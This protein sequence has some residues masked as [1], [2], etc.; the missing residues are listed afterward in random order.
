MKKLSD[1]K[2]AGRLALALAVPVVGLL[3][4]A[5]QGVLAEAD[6]RSI[7]DRLE[8]GTSLI[9]HLSA[10][11]HEVQR[12]RGRSNAVAQTA[13]KQGVA[14]YGAQ[15][16]V[17]DKAIADFQTALKAVDTSDFWPAV[18]TQLTE[19]EAALNKLSAIRAETRSGSA[20][21]TAVQQGYTAVIQEL[22]D[23]V[24]ALASSIRQG[25]IVR[26]L[27][28][29]ASLLKLKERAGQER[30][31]GS[32]GFASIEGSAAYQ[33]KQ[34]PIDKLAAMTDFAGRQ[35]AFAAS[36]EAVAPEGLARQLR[37]ILEG[38]VST[39]VA[40]FRATAIQAAAAAPSGPVPTAA[41]WFQATTARIDALKSFEAEVSQLLASDTAA[42]K[43]SATAAFWTMLA[44]A[45]AAAAATAV[46]VVIVARSITK[47]VGSLTGAMNQLAGG[48]KTVDIEGIQRK[49]EIGDMSRAVL[50]FKE[51][52]IKAD[53]LTAQQEKDRAAREARAARIVE[54][55][56]GFEQAVASV[57]Q[58]VTSASSELQ[59]TAGSMSS[60]AEETNVQASAVA[61]ASEQSSAN[62]Q[63]VSSAAEELSSSIQEIARQVHTS[64]ET[65]RT[66]A[67][68]A[69]ATQAVVESLSRSAAKIGDVVNLINA[70][71]AQTNLLALNATIE[72]AR[73]GDAGKGFAVVANEVKSLANQTAKATEEISQQIRSVQEETSHAVQA[74]ES[75]VASITAVNEVTANIASAVEQQ[76]AA[77]Q[78]IAR[79]VDQASAGAQEVSSNIQGVT[80]AAGEA[81]AAAEQV[82]SAA[83]E[84]AN[85]ATEMKTIVDK[86]ISDVQAA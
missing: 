85:K 44:A 62:V 35:A 24:D 5:G 20:N 31:V 7:M 39:K 60:I 52:M 30:A 41:E 28:L 71:A 42:L 36:F 83:G 23:P 21:A 81:G 79:N 67:Q 46:L 13:G 54:L 25:A 61:A 82:L 55:N 48:D 74:I 75:I 22:M 38:S 9:P 32:A 15:I 56:K 10:T 70:I 59:A 58:Y 45:L 33:I 72:A 77:T 19:A 1:I 37:G 73:A 26:D 17:V 27:S 69:E 14:E 4:F 34:F 64:T 50:V 68:N 47:P 65:S 51:A 78:E 16:E 84:L 63:T 11:V 43:D 49:D 66:A 80:A 29:Y 57:L 8:R 53:E 76:N 18:A 40:E 2:I 86:F 6:T 12:E 3:G